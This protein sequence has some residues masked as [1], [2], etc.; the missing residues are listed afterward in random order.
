MK[1]SSLQNIEEPLRFHEFWRLRTISCQHKGKSEPL[2]FRE[3][4]EKKTEI[5]N[6]SSNTSEFRIFPLLQNGAILFLMQVQNSRNLLVLILPPKSN[7]VVQWAGSQNNFERKKNPVNST[8]ATMKQF[9]TK[10]DSICSLGRS[11]RVYSACS[12]VLLSKRAAWSGNADLQ[13]LWERQRAQD[14]SQ[15]LCISL[16]KQSWNQIG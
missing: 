12:C 6:I 5:T 16:W 4:F 9:V 14:S 2:R 11:A 8:D 10:F 13:L 7:H 15:N 3:F 1:L